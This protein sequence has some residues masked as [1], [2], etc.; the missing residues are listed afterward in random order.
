MTR[1][2]PPHVAI[3]EA[4][5]QAASRG[6]LA[7]AVN[8]GAT[9][10]PF[11]FVLYDE[12]RISL[13]RIRRLRYAGYGVADIASSCHNEIEALRAMT[14]PPEIPLQL[15]VRGPDRHWHIYRVLPDSI[16]EIRA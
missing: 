13:V 1:G 15:H 4:Q 10:L 16:E 6:C 5:H 7:L 3:G 11:D 9:I 12:G 2:H 8:T 14:L